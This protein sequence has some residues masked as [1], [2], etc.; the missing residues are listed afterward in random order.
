VLGGD[1]EAAVRARRRRPEDREEGEPGRDDRPDELVE[2]GGEV[3]AVDRGRDRKGA[4]GD[5][6]GPAR[7]RAVD[8]GG[9]VGDV[10]GRAE[11]GLRGA[12]TVRSTSSAV[13][14]SGADSPTTSSRI[15]AGRSGVPCRRT[16]K[17]SGA[18]EAES[19]AS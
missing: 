7:G 18:G 5:G 4:R 2:R 3:L 17:L 10:S 12:E 9:D 19:W 11:R 13:C 8:V 16:W 6:D 1:D 14:G 15:G